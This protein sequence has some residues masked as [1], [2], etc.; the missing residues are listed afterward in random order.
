MQRPALFL[1]RRQGT[2]LC[3]LSESVSLQRPAF[4]VKETENRPLSPFPIRY[5]RF[6]ISHPAHTFFTYSINPFKKYPA[7][8][9]KQIFSRMFFFGQ[10]SSGKTKKVG[11]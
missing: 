7:E 6:R 5:I 10:L 1:F 3:L 9:K 2:V 8:E 11:I 4:F